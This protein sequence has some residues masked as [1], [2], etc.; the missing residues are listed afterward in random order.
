VTWREH[1]RQRSNHFTDTDNG[2]SVVVEKLSGLRAS[3]L[4]SEDLKE[5]KMRK[6]EERRRERCYVTSHCE[7][8][9]HEIERVRQTL[10]VNAAIQGTEELPVQLP[11]LVDIELLRAG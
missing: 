6:L 9:E 7:G 4:D 5:E 3:E 11:W 2:R 1:I 8:D 10:F